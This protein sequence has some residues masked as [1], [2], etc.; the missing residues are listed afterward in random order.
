MNGGISVLLL[1]GFAIGSYPFLFYVVL[2]I[3]FRIFMTMY[4]FVI[5]AFVFLLF[6]CEIDQP[7]ASSKKEV[8]LSKTDINSSFTTPSNADS[9]I[10]NEKNDISKKIDSQDDNLEASKAQFGQIEKIQANLLKANPDYRKQGNIHEQDGRIFAAEFPNCGLKDLSP[11]RGL[12]LNALDLS[13]NPVREIRHLRGMPLER[14]FLEYTSVESLTELKDAKLIELRLNGSPVRS[15]KGLE[16]QP[17]ENLYAVNTQINDISSLA[18]SNLRQLWLTE[19]PVSNLKPLEGLPLV[20]LTLHRTLVEDL[21]F[22]RKLPV[23]Q[24]LHIGETLITDLTPLKGVNLTRLVFSPERIKRGLD[25][26]KRL[27]NL[28]EIGTKF[29]DTGRDLTSP[30]N[31]WLKF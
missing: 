31:F 15:L 26:V 19:S 6:G 17:I 27:S 21:S 5:F 4:S 25:V 7:S 28:R 14:L 1:N 30:K 12:E 16:G 20:S 22:V 24:R 3:K 10:D 23:I 11:L 29:D 9:K 18:K 8:P 13:G 2:I